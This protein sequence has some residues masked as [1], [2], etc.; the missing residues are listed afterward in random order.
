M[1]HLHPR[2]QL[3]PCLAAFAAFGGSVMA[4]DTAFPAR[5]VQIVVPYSTGTT[6]DILARLLGP[7]LA[8]HWKVSV[9]TDNRPGTTG[10]IGLGSVAKAAPD[11]RA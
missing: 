7:L 11:G 9:V 2:S 4:Q 3:L 6:A 10:A 5:T 1:N 8:E